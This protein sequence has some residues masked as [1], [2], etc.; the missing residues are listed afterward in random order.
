MNFQCEIDQ[1]LSKIDI[2]R[3]HSGMKNAIQMQ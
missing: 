3:L 1:L 2:A